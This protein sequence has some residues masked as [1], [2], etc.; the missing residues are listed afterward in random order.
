MQWLRL[1]L[2]QSKSVY[3]YEEM[4][5][6]KRIQ[7]KELFYKQDILTLMFAKTFPFEY[8]YW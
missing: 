4:C 2:C 8:F 1:L 3:I 5:F 7:Y 6:E